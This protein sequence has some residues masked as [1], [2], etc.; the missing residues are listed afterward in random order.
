M[1]FVKFLDL[2]VITVPPC[3][4]ITMTSS[5]ILAIKKLENKKISCRIPTKINEGGLVNLACFDKT[6]ILTK[7]FMNF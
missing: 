5:T 3:I 6:G 1:F 4:T 2:I 7:D